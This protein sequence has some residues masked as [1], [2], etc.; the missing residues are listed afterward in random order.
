[1]TAAAAAL[2]TPAPPI[3][4]EAVMRRPD[5][6]APPLVQLRPTLT[7][8]QRDTARRES[9]AL[10]ATTTAATAT[11]ATVPTGP[12][13]AIATRPSRSRDDALALQA[14]LQGLKAQSITAI[15]TRLDVMAAQG[16]WRVV[17]WPHP[18]QDEAQV[19]LV[20]A[21]ARGLPVELIRF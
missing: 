4:T 18:R 12:V 19:L 2:P 3:D 15:P 6:P 13:F 1:M 21:R 10:R 5:D 14:V 9:Q 16:R 17:W 20:E 11:T 8:E 7:A